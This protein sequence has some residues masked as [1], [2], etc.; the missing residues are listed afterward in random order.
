VRFLIAGLGSSGRRHLRN[1]AALGEQD[2]ILYRT[3]QST[4]PDTDL[5]G[6]PVFTNL[7][8]AL[9]QKPQAVIVSNPTALHL[10]VAIPAAQAGCHLLIEKPISGSLERLG[11]L[12]A[13]VQQGGGQVLTGFQFRFHPG[14]QRAK[15]L[16]EEGRIGRPISLRAHWGEYLPGWHPWEDYRQGYSARSDLGGGAILTLCHPLDYARWLLGEVT[17]LW[18]FSGSLGDLGLEVEDTAEI[19]LRFKHSALGSVHVDYNQQPPTHHL[20]ISG[21]QGTLRWD[22]ADGAVEVYAVAASRWE[23]FPSPEGFERN[24]MFLAQME[25]FREVACGRAAPACTLQDG[26]RAL[27][28]ALAARISQD[29]GRRV[30]WS[31]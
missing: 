14:L 28:L 12:E 21:T 30:R 1:L 26:I 15:S 16:L 27:E 22:S 18:A 17:D 20:E 5:E 9:A 19:G 13:A 25:H 10:E 2:I 24:T 6:Y 23:R 4:L 7:G 31:S 29:E 8:A 11:E 3:H